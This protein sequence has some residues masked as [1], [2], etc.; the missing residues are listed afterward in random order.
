MVR[1]AS[2]TPEEARRAARERRLRLALVLAVALAL[3][4]LAARRVGL[5]AG[6]RDAVGRAEEAPGTPEP[7]PGDV[8]AG[9]ERSGGADP[10]ARAEALLR[11]RCADAATGAP[12]AGV[13]V[14]AEAPGLRR[15]AVTDERGE[16][17]LPWPRGLQGVVGARPCPAA[18]GGAQARALTPAERLG[19]AAVE[20]AVERAPVGPLAGRVVARHS[21]EGLPGVAVRLVGAGREAA[22]ATDA[23]GA[24]AVD[25]PAGAWRCE[26]ADP[27]PSGARPLGEL[28]LA[29]DP[30]AP[31]AADVAVDVGPSFELDVRG[32]APAGSVLRARLVEVPDPSGDAHAAGALW[33]SGAEWVLAAAEEER[34]EAPWSWCALREDGGLPR[35]WL[36]YAE[37][38]RP[39][40]RAVLLELEAAPPGAPEERT[41]VG[42]ARLDGVR[43]ARRAVTVELR[44]VAAIR[45]ALAVADGEATALD[46]A[47]VWLARASG[48]AAGP[49]PVGADGSFELAGLEP[50]PCVLSVRG[51]QL[52]ATD[53]A[54]E[55]APGT[56]R[57]ATVPL[58]RTEGP[59]GLRVRVECAR[60]HD[61]SP[62]LARVRAADGLAART[63][64]LRVGGGPG[65]PSA[66]ELELPD[67]AAG[68]YEVRVEPLG[69]EHG[70]SP[71]LVRLETPAPAAL[72]VCRE[73]GAPAR[74]RVDVRDEGSGAPLE[75]FALELGGERLE[76]FTWPESRPA[77]RWFAWPRRSESTWSVFAPGHRPASGPGDAEELEGGGTL[78]VRLEEGFGARLSVRELGSPEAP[79]Q[80]LPPVAGVRAVA[81]GEDAGETDAWGELLVSLPARPERI[82]LLHPAWR[83]VRL[84]ARPLPGGAHLIVLVELR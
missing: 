12:V 60:G 82:E 22:A 43:G 10:A 5:S 46:D 50:G 9:G 3:L 63:A 84:V 76:P 49:W 1:G 56:N 33:W 31:V 67:L 44:P 36:R 71:D 62:V 41:H 61:R 68:A 23:A 11:G 25:L 26:L 8:P 24:F 21:G 66:E 17:E 19:D 51:P 20:L 35:P 4:W 42:R 52:A 57:I 13:E 30:A 80:Q 32:A 69:G 34:G 18:P 78:R 2:P 73:G 40:A 14:F 58:R 47:R 16:F 64:L 6:D 65:V 74:H 28:E 37:F 48:P 54:L 81:D 7:P 75:D 72:F 70:F 53:V 29:H 45:G 38:E 77:G 59:R 27:A 79:W 83:A 55:L 39:P 15:E